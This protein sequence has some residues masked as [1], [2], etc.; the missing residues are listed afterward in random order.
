MSGH[1][2]LVVGASLA[3]LRAVEAARQEGYGG[4]IRLVGEEPH[5]PY[6]RPPLS[7][8]FLEPGSEQ[9]FF[10]ERDYLT[11]ELGVELLLGRTAI[12]LDSERRLVRVAT[13]DHGKGTA[14]GVE[15]LG[16]DTLIIATGARARRL[17]G[18]DGLAGVLPLRTLDDAR[19]IQEAIAARARIV[20]IGAGFIGAE[21]ASTARAQGLN[22]VVL[23]AMPTPLVRA[24]GEP[25]GARLASLHDQ[26]GADLR[27]GVGV[28]ALLGE[29][30]VTGVRLDD[31]TT[32]D[33]DLVVVGVGTIPN[34]EWLE[35]SGVELENGVRCD[36]FLATSVTGVYAA[37]D[38]A[39]W[40]NPALDR[41]MRLEHWTSAAEQGAAAARNAV[42]KGAQR[43]Y[44]TVPYFWSDQ[45]GVRIQFVGSQGSGE[46]L[47]IED[48]LADGQRL[49][50]L[51]RDGDRLA[52]ALTVSG[53]SDVMK[54]RTLI[55][56]GGSWEAGVA[57]ARTRTEA[58]RARLADQVRS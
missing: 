5:L 57:L 28:A 39:S 21:L 42:G 8:E 24:V 45:Y 51:Y 22:P 30:R 14:E 31:G 43:A 18:T 10:R 25:M 35:G 41:Q 11:G 53:Q 56:R 46:H 32:I 9:P 37:G 4:P 38:V 47:V 13:G 27:C 12:G 17:P 16:Y 1:G 52:G 36:E 3:G 23:E 20:V 54:Y 29:G 50:T 26:H 58:K 49:T 48:A 15:E 6:D 33:A 34:T 40:W 44:R 7:K 2:L 55:D 19:L